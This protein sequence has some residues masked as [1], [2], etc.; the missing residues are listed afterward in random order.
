MEAT[1]SSVR[2]KSKGGTTV[3]TFGLRILRLP[4][5]PRTAGASSAARMPIA[6]AI[7]GNEHTYYCFEGIKPRR[8]YSLHI[9]SDQFR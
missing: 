4:W 3:C 2:P 9:T 6:E 1:L 7:A 8:N 5:S